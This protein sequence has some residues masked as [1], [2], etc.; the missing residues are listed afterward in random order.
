MD[1]DTPERYIKMYGGPSGEQY[2]TCFHCG[3]RE[4]LLELPG[5]SVQLFAVVVWPDRVGWY[6]CPE[7][8]PQYRRIAEQRIFEYNL[9]NWLMQD[10]TEQPL[11]FE[12]ATHGISYV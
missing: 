1:K 8:R 12:E 9:D 10:E 3:R 4:R 11:G 5:A 6:V 7:C 2:A